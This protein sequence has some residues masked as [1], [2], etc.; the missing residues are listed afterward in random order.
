MNALLLFGQ[1]QSA[2]TAFLL[3]TAIDKLARKNYNSG[4]ARPTESKQ[5]L[6]FRLEALQRELT[7]EQIA[8]IIAEFQACQYGPAEMCCDPQQECNLQGQQQQPPPPNADIGARNDEAQDDDSR[9]RILRLELMLGDFQH[10]SSML[11]TRIASFENRIT[12][13]EAN[14]TRRNARLAR[15]VV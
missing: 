9:D 2:W 1:V 11:E 12:A 10:Y 13:L 15:R 7:Q 14:T 6:Y 8:S 5:G 3:R 4:R